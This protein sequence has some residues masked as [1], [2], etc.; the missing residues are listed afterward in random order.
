MDFIAIWY[1]RLC[2]FRDA[3]TRGQA[4][5]SELIPNFLTVLCNRISGY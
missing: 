4:L 5:G 2:E 3:L 1:L